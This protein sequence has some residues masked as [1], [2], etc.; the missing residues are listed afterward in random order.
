[1]D[2]WYN[3]SLPEYPRVLIRRET[4]TP[5]V[6]HYRYENHRTSDSHAPGNV[7]RIRVHG[8]RSDGQEVEPPRVTVHRQTSAGET[9]GR[10]QQLVKEPRVANAKV[11]PVE[12][13][14]RTASP[15]TGIARAQ[16]HSVQRF[17]Q[18]EPMRGVPLTSL[19][20]DLNA[21]SIDADR[22]HVSNN[23]LS[24]GYDS[25]PS[26]T[27][28]FP[29]SFEKQFDQFTSEVISPEQ[30]STS[31]NRL[32]NQGEFRSLTTFCFVK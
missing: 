2:D 8:R 30:T 14:H 17:S 9:T 11:F 31:L 21:N 23:H 12:V 1:M 25:P 19:R 24:M 32:R 22:L 3:D 5:N 15:V 27:N 18:K 16:K 26:K 20:R 29:F 28:D 10:G 7:I 4:D 13:R 6:H